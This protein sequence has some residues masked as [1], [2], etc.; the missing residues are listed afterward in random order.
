MNVLRKF[1]VIIAV[2]CA[3]AAGFLHDAAADLTPQQERGKQIYFSGTS[4]SGG[5]ITAYFGKDLLEIPGEGATCS[6][7]HGYDGLGR[8]E[9]GVIPTNITWT[10][11][12]KSYGHVHPDGFEHAVFTIES[13]KRYMKEGYYPGEKR[14]DPAMPIYALSDQDLDDLVA[15][16]MILDQHLDPGL[17]GTTVR[18][19]VVYPDGGRLQETGK[20]VEHIISAYFNRI[21]DQGGIYGRKLEL[22]PV[23]VPGAAEAGPGPLTAAIAK[24]DLFALVSPIVPGR[25]RDLVA[26][27]EQE[28]I[29]VVGPFTL[30]PIEATELNHYTFYIF[31]G[32]GDHLLAL[33]EF[34]AEEKELPSHAALLL[35]PASPSLKDL[36]PLITERMQSRGWKE[37][38]TVEYGEGHFDPDGIAAKLKGHNAGVVLFM[39]SEREFRSLA[40]AVERSGWKGRILVPG[41]LVGGAV[42]DVS[43]E[44][45]L[46]LAIAYPTLPS[47]RNEEGVR[48]LMLLSQGLPGSPF[49]AERILA[50]ASAKLFAEGMGG[51]GKA[52]SRTGLISA[53][54][55]VSAFRTGLTP[56]MGFRQNKRVGAYGAYVVTFTRDQGEGKGLQDSQRWVELVE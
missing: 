9:S 14:G 53:L 26:A 48:D 16:L 49:D 37:V 24:N 54:E 22:I 28:G 40:A 12:M 33:V 19:G 39:G 20:A 6:S 32:L 27:A 41:V 31:S 44:L 18:I 1:F 56:E 11:L 2:S 43:D 55:H 3:L 17:T 34:A 42:N 7:C 50:Y 25:E 30:F 29:P 4:P 52:L 13:L 15:F 46:Q 35:V 23:R 45:K 36:K 38:I 47:D 21:N 5:K 51:A 8:P 10:Y